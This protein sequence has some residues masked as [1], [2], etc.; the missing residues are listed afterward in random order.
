MDYQNINWK[1]IREEEGREFVKIVEKYLSDNLNSSE[2]PNEMWENFVK[3]TLPE[4][5][6]HLGFL[7]KTPEE[8]IQIKSVNGEILTESK[9]IL[10]RWVQYFEYLLNEKLPSD[11]VVSSEPSNISVDQI[12]I[13]EVKAAIS[14]TKNGKQLG[15]DFIPVELWKV[16]SDIAH[17][18]LKE[19]FNK[20]LEGQAMPDVWRNSFLTSRYKDKGDTSECESYRGFVLECHTLKIWEKILSTRIHP[21]CNVSKNQFGFVNGRSSNN[22]I[23]TFLNLIATSSKDKVDLHAVF[24]DLEKAFD[25]VQRELVWEVLRSRKLPEMYV[26]AII[27]TYKDCTTQIKLYSCD[28]SEKFLINV[29]LHQGSALS[30]LLFTTFIDTIT[31]DIQDPL[32]WTILYADDILL[33]QRTKEEAEFK[34]NQWNSTLRKNGLR[35]CAPKT[36]YMK[37]SFADPDFIGPNETLN[38]D[39]NPVKMTDN[40]N[41][42]GSKIS[43]ETV[44][45]YL[46]K[47]GKTKKKKI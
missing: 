13:Q 20:I 37:F 44:K 47:S 26:G 10:E 3:F 40:Y 45:I 4:A 12:T 32:P 18:W 46:G 39:G 15:P 43:E 8:I 31:A 29:G 1:K 5:G 7:T 34:L 22:A 27:D 21:Y 23:N 28:T 14:K 35:I 6:K 33:I 30:P 2:F 25:R 38:L 41:Y 36:A 16:L 9:A 19:L 11:E 42:L 24:I 17:D